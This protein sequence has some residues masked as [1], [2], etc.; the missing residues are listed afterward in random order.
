[1]DR[2][3][4]EAFREQAEGARLPVNDARPKT[5]ACRAVALGTGFGCDCGGAQSGQEGERHVTFRFWRR[6]KR[7]EELNEELRSH[8]E[9]AMSDRMERGEKPETARGAALREMGNLGLIKEVTR[10][11]WGWRW[12][13]EL[14][15]DVRYG[16]RAMGRSPG[17]YAVAVVILALGIGANT[18]IFS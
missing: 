11:K 6:Q 8:L 15:Q 4:L 2:R 9:M 7:D 5:V 18:A 13:E 12:L 16:L 10:D 17:F 3:R 14:V 1:M